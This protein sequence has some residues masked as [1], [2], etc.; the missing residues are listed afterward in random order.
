MSFYN[1]FRN[2]DRKAFFKWYRSGQGLF[3]P[4]KQRKAAI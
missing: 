4:L 3:L 1:G 2:N